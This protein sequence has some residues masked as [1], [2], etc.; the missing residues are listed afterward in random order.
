MSSKNMQGG[1]ACWAVFNP[2]Y[3]ETGYKY[4]INFTLKI[5]QMIGRGKDTPLSPCCF[6]MENY[7]HF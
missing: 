6:S 5:W 1:A 3:A 4:G 2:D 7:Q